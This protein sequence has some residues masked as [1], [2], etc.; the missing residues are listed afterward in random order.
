[1]SPNRDTDRIPPESRPGEDV[2]GGDEDGDPT[3]AGRSPDN[4][5]VYRMYPDDA[6][7]VVDPKI[8]GSLLLV[9]AILLFFPEPITS[10]IGLLLVL[11]GAFVGAIDLLT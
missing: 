3:M 4:E 6:S 9:G 8:Y 7:R 2:Y 10:T 1:M 5:G 11:V